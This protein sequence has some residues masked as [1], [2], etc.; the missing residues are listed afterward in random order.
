MVILALQCLVSFGLLLPFDPSVA[1]LQMV[2]QARALHR[3]R[4][5]PG[6]GRTVAARADERC[7]LVAAVAS[8]SIEN[9]PRIYFALLLIISG[10]VNGAF[11]AQNL[12]LFFLFYELELIPWLL[13]AIWVAPTVPM[14]P[15]SS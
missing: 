7:S 8:R 9:R 2:E 15:P 6:R 5:R 11:L 14:P 4:L 1:G 13:I 3:P 12:L 10:A